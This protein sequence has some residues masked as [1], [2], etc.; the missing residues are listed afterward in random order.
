MRKGPRERL[1][2]IPAVQPREDKPDYLMTVD[3][4]P[5]EQ[6]VLPGTACPGY[7]A[8]FTCLISESQR[9]RESIT[10]GILDSCDR[11]KYCT[12]VQKSEECLLKDLRV[13][14]IHRLP[15]PHKGDE[16]HHSGWNA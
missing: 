4:D 12:T 2:Y 10:S 14:V 1:A 3:L 5:G 7:P 13:Q 6:D 8:C 15:M 16:L 11:N 9:G